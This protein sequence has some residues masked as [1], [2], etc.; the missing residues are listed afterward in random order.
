MSLPV[1]ADARL[2]AVAS[3]QHG[4]FTR[5]QAATAGLGRGQIDRRL[6][7]G[8]WTRVLPRVYRDASSPATVGQQLW[9]CVLWSG[10]GS[11]LSH[12]TAAALWRIDTPPVSAPEV[13][14]PYQR[15]PKASGVT[16]HRT[17]VLTPSD[18]GTV[19]GLPVTTPA[20]TLVD[21][22]SRLDDEHLEVVLERARALGLVTPDGLRAHLEA[23]GTNGRMGAARLL[24]LGDALRATPPSVSALEVKVARLLRTRLVHQPDRAL[25]VAAGGREFRLPFA[26]RAPRVGVDC[27]DRDETAR[28]RSF[29]EDRARL[30]ALAA[31]GWRVL[32]VTWADVVRRPE[33]VVGQVS[34]ALRARA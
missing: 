2:A 12:A 17:S 13:V 29:A 32:V 18:V 7:S 28:R 11:A 26:W 27:D 14:V 20:R 5:A 31:A 21:L 33:V 3:R 23:M 15:A 30:G 22:S 34:A 19:V 4:V 1:F 6:R 8:A 24:A 16:V 10:P 9:A 25:P